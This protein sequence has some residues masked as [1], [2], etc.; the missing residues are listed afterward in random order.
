MSQV[1]SNMAAKSQLDLINQCYEAYTSN[2]TVISTPTPSEMQYSTTF[3]PNSWE[4]EEDAKEAIKAGG[5]DT[6]RFDIDP[7]TKTIRYNAPAEHT[8]GV[9]DFYREMQNIWDDNNVPKDE[10]LEPLGD[11]DVIEINQTLNPE[12]KNYATIGSGTAEPKELWE[13]LDAG[14]GTWWGSEDGYG[15]YTVTITVPGEYKVSNGYQEYHVDVPEGNTHI[16]QFATIG[17]PDLPLTFNQNIVVQKKV[18]ND[19]HTIKINTPSGTVLDPLDEVFQGTSSV[20][21]SIGKKKKKK[22][23]GKKHRKFPLPAKKLGSSLGAIGALSGLGNL[24]NLGSIA[25][26]RTNIVL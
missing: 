20:S 15:A 13:Q 5:I 12:K 25:S 16:T 22:F 26:K 10:T 17:S 21:R 6:A 24:G 9:A 8:Y 14:N 2:N 3:F 1:A 4:I 18:P 7:V 19:S 23:K 11:G